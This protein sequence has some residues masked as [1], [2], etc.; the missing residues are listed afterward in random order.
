MSLVPPMSHTHAFPRFKLKN[1]ENDTRPQPITRW[2]KERIVRCSFFL[3]IDSI[4]FSF[5]EFIFIVCLVDFSPTFSPVQYQCSITK[6][7]QVPNI[8][9]SFE[10]AIWQLC[11][12]HFSSLKF[13]QM[14]QKLTDPYQ[15]MSNALL[16]Q[17]HNIMALGS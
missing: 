8:R 17:W 4:F 9:V 12:F 13:F 3:K 6:A 10:L 7:F 14:A 11:C 16:F 15:L 2:S 1:L 5:H